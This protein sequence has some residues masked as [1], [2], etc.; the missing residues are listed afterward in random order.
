MGSRMVLHSATGST[1]AF[2]RRG[3][4]SYAPPPGSDD[5]LTVA[6]STVALV[7]FVTSWMGENHFQS[8]PV[9][10]YGCILLLAAISY[11]LLQDQIL[12]T[13]GKNSPLAKAIGNDVKGKISTVIYSIGIGV[14]FYNSWIAGFMYLAVAIMWLVPDKR[15]EKALKMQ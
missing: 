1:A 3:D 9:A 7:P 11:F 6:K 8:L 12:R 13:H 14:S 4:G 2:A 15:I 5:L 10:L